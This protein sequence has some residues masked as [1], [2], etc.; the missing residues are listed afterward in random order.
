MSK[1]YETDKKYRRKKCSFY[2]KEDVY[3]RILEISETNKI[4]LSQT[5]ERLMVKGYGGMI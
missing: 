1:W 2:L 3:N 5:G 4:S